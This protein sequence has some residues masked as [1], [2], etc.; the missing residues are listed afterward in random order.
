MFD[1]SFVSG[2]NAKPVRDFHSL[3][4]AVVFVATTAS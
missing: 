3:L 2:T 1:I 4:S